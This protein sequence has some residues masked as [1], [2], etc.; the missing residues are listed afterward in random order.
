MSTLNVD[1]INEYTTDGKVNV[2][3]DIKLASGK[4]VLNSDGK[5]TGAL[6]LLSTQTASDDTAIIFD[7]FVD[8]TKYSHYKIVFDRLK[9]STDNVEF[10]FKFRSGGASGS[11]MTGTYNQ[12]GDYVYVDHSNGYGTFGNNSKT[13]YQVYDNNVGSS[14]GEAVMGEATLFP[15]TGDTNKNVTAMT[16]YNMKQRS[17]DTMRYIH[18]A[19][20]LEN[21]TAVT[22]FNFYASSGNVASGTIRIY[23]V[24]I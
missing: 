1:N 6:V 7:N 8:L 15:A 3:H 5:S 10:R 22:G 16:H 20:F 4:S 24:S 13:D 18:R 14:T 11:N 9:P 23:G 2:G 17:D 21:T 19:T 12:G